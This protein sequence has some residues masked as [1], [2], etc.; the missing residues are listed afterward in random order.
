[1]E[2]NRSSSGRGFS[3]Q[4]CVT[5]AP[6]FMSINFTFFSNS[7]FPPLFFFFFFSPRRP[8]IYIWGKEEECSVGTK[9]VCSTV[10]GG[11]PISHTGV[12]V[13]ALTAHQWTIRPWLLMSCYLAHCR[14]AI[15]SRCWRQ[16]SKLWRRRDARERSR[17]GGGKR[18]WTHWKMNG[19]R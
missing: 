19:T 4:R 16:A 6:S 7:L 14:V 9:C 13:C 12:R 11:K 1:M 15:C 17:G 5:S 3:H 18:E 10:D 8:L 2:A